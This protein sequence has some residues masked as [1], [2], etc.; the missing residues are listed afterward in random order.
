MSNNTF[1]VENFLA[2]I[3]PE[4]R[5]QLTT[6]FQEV[7]RAEIISQLNQGLMTPTAVKVKSPKSK[8]NKV[9]GDKRVINRQVTNDGTERSASQFIRDLDKTTP[10]LTG[11]QVIEEAA[12]LGMEISGPLVYNVRQGVKKATIAKAEKAAIAKAERAAAKAEKAA[13]TESI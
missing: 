1:S 5:T 12:K 13:S 4:M 11:P 2:T 8:A 10:G 3:S 9:Q 7:A 6:H